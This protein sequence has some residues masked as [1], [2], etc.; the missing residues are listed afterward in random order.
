MKLIQKVKLRMS[1]HAIVS[2]SG[3]EEKV[4]GGEPY[5]TNL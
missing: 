3:T 2:T 4:W 1:K 5:A